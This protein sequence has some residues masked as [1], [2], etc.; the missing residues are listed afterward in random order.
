MRG[1]DRR[2]GITSDQSWCEPKR[3]RIPSSGCERCLRRRRARRR[4]TR[5]RP[6]RVR[7]TRRRRIG[8]RATWTRGVKL[9]RP[10]RCR[11]AARRTMRRQAPRARAKRSR[12]ACNGRRAWSRRWRAR[13]SLSRRTT[14][15]PSS[16]LGATAPSTRLTRRCNATTRQTSRRRWRGGGPQSHAEGRA[17]RA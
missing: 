16:R 14:L 8:R 5:R 17:P 10:R 1:G 13:V 4:A 15:S 9:V 2:T 7:R 12:A 11:P 3:L 6:M